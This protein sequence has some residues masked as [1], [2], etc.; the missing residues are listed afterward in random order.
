MLQWMLGLLCEVGWHHRT[1]VYNSR[2][3]KCAQT[4]ICRRCGDQGYRVRHEVDHWE[5]D[6]EVKYVEIGVCIRCEQWQYRNK[7]SGGGGWGP[8]A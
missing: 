2:T 1:W 8:G 5:S 6:V 7:G 4:R 3:Q